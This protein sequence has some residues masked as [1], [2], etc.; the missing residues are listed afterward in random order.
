MATTYSS[1]YDSSGQPLYGFPINPPMGSPGP[2]S[3]Q[4]SILAATV[5]A[6][7]GEF[8]ALVPVAEGRFVTLLEFTSSDFDTDAS[9]EL[10]MDIVLRVTDKDGTHT[11]TILFNAGTAFQAAIT[12]TRVVICHGT[13]GGVQVSGAASGYGHV[14]L[15]TVAQAA[16]G[17]AGTIELTVHQR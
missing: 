15:K 1:L 2:V 13:R 8:I 14:G 17:A 4:E 5:E 12:T 7:A 9:P 11:D 10:D 16:T 6:A 3:V